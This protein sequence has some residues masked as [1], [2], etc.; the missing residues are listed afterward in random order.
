MR[1]LSV[2]AA[3]RELFIDF[4]ALL[5]N[6]VLLLLFRLQR[7]GEEHGRVHFR[8]LAVMVLCA[9]VL[10]MLTVFLI[11]ADIPVH[12]ALTLFVQMTS[13]MLNIFVVYFFSIYVEN[14]VLQ[15]ADRRRGWHRFNRAVLLLMFFAVAAYYVWTVP[16]LYIAGRYP[17][18]SGW[19]RIFGGFA[20][21][22]WFLVYSISLLI[23]GDAMSARTKRILP[24]VFALTTSTLVVQAAIGMTPRLDYL[25]QSLALFVFYFTVETSDYLNLLRTRKELEEETK[26]TAFLQAFSGR[27]ATQGRALLGMNDLI[28]KES[29]DEKVLMYARSIERTAKDLV[30][31]AA[32]MPERQEAAILQD[33]AAAKEEAQSEQDPVR[34][35]SAPERIPLWERIRRTGRYGTTKEE[36]ESCRERILIWNEQSAKIIL[37]LA[38]Y[39][40]VLAYLATFVLNIMKE[41]RPAFLVFF[42]I[43]GVCYFLSLFAKQFFKTHSTLMAYTG[44]LVILSFAIVTGSQH[45]DERAIDYPIMLIWLCLLIVDNAWRMAGVI[46]V[47]DLACFFMLYMTK[48]PEIAQRDMY[49]ILMYSTLVIVGHFLLQRNRMGEILAAGRYEAVQTELFSTTERLQEATEEA[50]RASHSKSD[51]L[52]NMSHEI[53]TPINAV[54]GMNEMILR[55]SRDEKIRL[56][57]HNVENAGKNLLSIIN[58]IL[59]FSKIEA[60]RME[61]TN[62]EYRLS[63]VLND[64]S[65]MITFRARAKDLSF[66]VNVDETL[67][68]VLFGDEVRVRQVITN[69]LNNAVKYTN[70]GS[71]T[72][73]VHGERRQGTAAS[74]GE[75]ETVR[76]QID[77][78]IAVSDTGIGIRED[79]LEKLFSKFER[80]DLTQTNT[81]EGTGLGLA[82]TKNLLSLMGGTVYV[83]SV[84]GEGSTFTLRIPQGVVREDAIG[85]FRERSEQSMQTKADYRE[86]FRAPDARILVVDDT[87]MNLVVIEGLLKQTQLQI[88]TATGGRKAL[89]LTQD[90][91]Y[92]L[93]LMDQRM[94]EMGGTETLEAIRK[95]E[96]GSNP[97][98][99]VICLT[100]DAVQGAR[101]R[102][103]AEGFTDYLSKPIEILSLEAALMKHLPQEKVTRMKKEETDSRQTHQAGDLQAAAAPVTEQKETHLSGEEAFRFVEE[104]TPQLLASLLELSA[105]LKPYLEEASSAEE[106]LPEMEPEEL[107]ELYEAVAEFAGMYDQDGIMRLFAQTEGYAA[108]AAEKERFERVRQCARDADWSGLKEALGS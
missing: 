62:G 37:S 98:T 3:L 67:P 87:E 10:S 53:R 100:A 8:N 48:A 66:R 104:H 96:H 21:E 22:F 39:G 30:T 74:K 46:A 56:Y 88:D 26:R 20:A 24:V 72:L 43:T 81:I 16:K 79:D 82:I 80:V 78:I 86:T 11:Y 28:L 19:F 9:N 90:T 95:Q 61:I 77:L 49:N 89:E 44:M 18:A 71:V 12:R 105:S 107:E 36:Y 35:T 64:V 70:E 93:I 52:A 103:L 50:T 55:E 99:P 47:M 58:D 54:L 94:P 59:D 42:C 6:I 38:F 40:F 91:A 13:Y 15:H 102:Y 41:F 5:F 7:G 14:L 68:D 69:V 57:A 51:F 76:G 84:Y 83:D 85:N 23:T 2:L 17:F 34:E 4:A 31:V 29:T 75:N 73:A 106:A 63:S 65:N 33:T 45:A 32:E 101:E 92:D 97:E 25:G 27:V 108:P 1:E 60:G